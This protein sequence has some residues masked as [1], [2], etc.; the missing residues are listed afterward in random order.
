MSKLGL[1]FSLVPPATRRALF[2]AISHFR[3]P[4]SSQ[5]RSMILHG[6]AS[7]QASWED[8]DEQACQGM[9]EGIIRTGKDFNTHVR[10]T[11]YTQNR[12]F[13]LSVTCYF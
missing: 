11:N 5:H 8:L 1:H 2:R 13:F 9:L 4:E 10:K 7:M 6:L 3:E 12:S